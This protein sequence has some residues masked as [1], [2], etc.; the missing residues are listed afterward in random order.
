MPVLHLIC[1]KEV[2]RLIC[3][4][5]RVH[6][7]CQIQFQYMVHTHSHGVSTSPGEVDLTSPNFYCII[8]FETY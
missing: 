3:Q 4:K 6:L 2:L 8:P 7:V 1:Q 5:L